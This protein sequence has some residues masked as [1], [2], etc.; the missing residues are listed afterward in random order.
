MR[1]AILAILFIF[2]VL[3][4]SA[5]DTLRNNAKVRRN[6]K[7]VLG[8]EAVL[9]AASM[10]GLYFAWYADYPQSKFHFFNDNNEWLLMDKAGHL[11]SSYRI[12]HFGYSALRLAGC[13]E[14]RAIWYGGTLGLAFMT[15]VEVFDGLSEGWGFSWGDMAAN[16]LGTGLFIGQQCLWHEQRIVVKYSFHTTEFPKYRPDLLGE[17][18]IQQTIKDYNG[19][20]IWASCNFKSMFLKQESK[21]PA[22]L[23]FAFG[24]GA[25][26]MTGGFENS[27]EYKGEPIP[28]Y[29]RKQQFY[30]SLDIDFNRIPTNNKF[31]KYTFRVL[32][33][34][35]FPFPAIE[36]NTGNEWV[37]HW[38]YF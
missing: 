35:K 10:T 16:A 38:I 26:G 4:A 28:Y 30:F 22:W 17:N 6:V 24:Y 34:F 19:I 12:G 32:N 13:E 9:Y 33:I 5:Q 1:K 29:E 14:N 36:Y 20:T 8:T 15:T 3:T 11:A 37:W 7:I 31:L 2:T 27:L 21:F 25:T 18:F 23:N